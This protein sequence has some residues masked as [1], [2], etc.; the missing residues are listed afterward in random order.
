MPAQPVMAR[1]PWKISACTF[2]LSC[3]G[4]LPRP[5]GSKPKSAQA[6]A[7]SSRQAVGPR[8]HAH[9]G[10]ASPC[11]AV[12]TS[13]SGAEGHEL[14]CHL[15]A[16]SLLN[17]LRTANQAAIQVVGHHLGVAGEPAARASTDVIHRVH[18]GPEG[19]AASAFVR[20]PL[21]GLLLRPVLRWMQQL[22][23]DCSPGR[24]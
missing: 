24:G 12:H 10:A 6:R 13:I 11:K 20:D 3:S 14:R 5:R 15:D 21:I 7:G 4:E 8:W 22:S 16:A 18:T 19:A 9:A 1:R 23:L 17:K 2:Q